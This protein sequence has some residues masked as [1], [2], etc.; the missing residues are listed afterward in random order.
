M[1]AAAYLVAEDARRRELPV[2]QAL[3]ALKR[4]WAGLAD[5]RLLEVA[6]ARD[7]LD[8]LV[9]ACIKAYYALPGAPGAG[10]PPGK[11][12]TTARVSR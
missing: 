12:S 9:T 7:L 10:L 3:V 5:V 4:E 2:P 11:R 8:V 6:Q 1:L